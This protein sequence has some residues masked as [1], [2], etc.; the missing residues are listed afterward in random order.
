[1]SMVI[2]CRADRLR[3]QG[4]SSRDISYYCESHVGLVMP[5]PRE[6]HD[7]FQVIL[8]PLELIP[9][10]EAVNYMDVLEETETCQEMGCSKTP[11]WRMTEMAPER[12]SEEVD[13][14]AKAWAAAVKDLSASQ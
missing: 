5:N 7:I 4:M 6:D 2:V 9:D 14:E 3:G 13:R 12:T 1:M 11:V 8:D 10:E